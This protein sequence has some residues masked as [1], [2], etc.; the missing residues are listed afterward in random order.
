MCNYIQNMLDELPLE[1]QSIARTLAVSHQFDLNPEG[2]K[3]NVERA[4]LFHHI[5]AKLLYLC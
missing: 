1:I 4:Q 2:K 3:L 5:V